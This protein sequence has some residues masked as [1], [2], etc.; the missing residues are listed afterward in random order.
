MRGAQK[1]L[2]ST[3]QFSTTHRPPAPTDPTSH[4]PPPT[5]EASSRC[6]IRNGPGQRTTDSRSAPS[7][8]NSVPTTPRTPPTPDPRTPHAEGCRTAGPAGAGG[9]TGQRSTLEHPPGN[10]ATHHG[11]WTVAVPGVA[12]HRPPDG[13]R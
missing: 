6:E 13:N 11:R 7:G 12:L 8:P 5:R 2:A 4:P 1:M 10:V 9:R 3:V